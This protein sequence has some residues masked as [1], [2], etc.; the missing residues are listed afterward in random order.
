MTKAGGHADASP[1]ISGTLKGLT[2]IWDGSRIIPEHQWDYH[3]HYLS[4]HA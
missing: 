1:A 4:W 2:L 3:E